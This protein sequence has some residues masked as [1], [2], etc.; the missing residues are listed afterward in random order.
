MH[1][2]YQACIGEYQACMGSTFE[3]A[4]RA[5]AGD[6]V[7]VGEGWGGDLVDVWEVLLGEVQQP[8]RA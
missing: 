2:E 3:R 8:G 1:G 5:V 7:D 6:G 4:E